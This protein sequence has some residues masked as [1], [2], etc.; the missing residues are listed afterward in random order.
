MPIRT[1]QAAP[2]LPST[3]WAFLKP[4]PLPGWAALAMTRLSLGGAAAGTSRSRKGLRPR[5]RANFERLRRALL[6]WC[7]F[8][9]V[10][11]LSARRRVPQFFHLDYAGLVTGHDLLTGA[12]N[13]KALG[14]PLAVEPG[15]E[16]P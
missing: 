10:A 13:E 4:N 14:I 9:A 6:R 16:Q 8:D 7:E 3:F 12:H 5:T 1:V 11:R 2:A 15:L